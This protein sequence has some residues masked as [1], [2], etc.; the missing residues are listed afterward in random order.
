MQSDLAVRLAARAVRPPADFERA[1]AAAERRHGAA[2]Y[3]P[4][5]PVEELRPGTYYLEEVDERWRRIYAR[6]PP[7][8]ETEPE[9]PGGAQGPSA[10]VLSSFA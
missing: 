9:P 4:Q 3:R 7:V 8:S 10:A 1:M 2:P 6:R 5:Q